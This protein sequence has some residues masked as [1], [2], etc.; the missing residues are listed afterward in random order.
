MFKKGNFSRSCYTLQD[1]Q[2]FARY[3]NLSEHTEEKSPD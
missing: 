3:A 2:Q 1:V